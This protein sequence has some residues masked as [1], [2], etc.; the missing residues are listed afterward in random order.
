MLERPQIVTEEHLTYLDYLRE[1]GVTNMFG[2]GSY[3]QEEFS[4]NANDAKFILKYWMKTFSE[5][6]SKR[7]QKESEE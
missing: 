5:R 6:Q 7:G 1:S 2:A 3:L 4:L